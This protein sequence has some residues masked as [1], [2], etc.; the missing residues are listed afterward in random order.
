MHLVN[1]KTISVGWQKLDGVNGKELSSISP[2]KIYY[3]MHHSL[4]SKSF[5]LNL[6]SLY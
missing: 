6:S 4:V 3:T 1:D 2:P 5:D